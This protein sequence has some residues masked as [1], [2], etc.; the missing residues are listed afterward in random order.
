MPRK[1]I[2]TP[3]QRY[4]AAGKRPGTPVGTRLNDSALA[5]LDAV[6]GKTARSAW[7]LSLIYRELKINEEPPAPKKKLA[8][9]G[10]RK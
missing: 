2:E 10:N 8:G 1:K 7:L 9:K 5:R 3:Q 4:E 6:R